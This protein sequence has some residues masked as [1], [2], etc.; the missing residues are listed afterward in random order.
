MN[1]IKNLSAGW[2]REEMAQLVARDIPDGAYVN[3]GYCHFMLGDYDRAVESIRV[4]VRLREAFST[5]WVELGD[6]C[7]WSPKFQSQ[8]RE[9]YEKA[10]ETASAELAL[11]P[12]NARA[13]ASQA[14]AFARTGNLEAARRSIQSAMKLDPENPEHFFRAARIAN[15][16][17]NPVESITWLQRAIA[18]G[19]SRVD[20]ERHPEFAQ[21]RQT[22]AVRSLLSVRSQG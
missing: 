15:L 19:S 20:L 3:L 4:A 5:Y 7:V 8:A 1:A 18:A 10:I 2:T 14:I 17:G 6:A 21:L 11:N 12:R 9:A 16:S 13:H 22:E